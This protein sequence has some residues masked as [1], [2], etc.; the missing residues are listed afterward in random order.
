MSITT[1]MIRACAALLFVSALLSGC[2]A[3]R[4]QLAGS[5]PID[6][7]RRALPSD[8]PVYIRVAPVVDNRDP[9]EAYAL[10]RDYRMGAEVMR[11]VQSELSNHYSSPEPPAGFEDNLIILQAKI[12]RWDVSVHKGMWNSDVQAVAQIELEL[13]GA[14]YGPLYRARYQADTKSN[15]PFAVRARVQSVLNSAMDAAVEEIFT[16][17]KL[18]RKISSA[19]P[20]NVG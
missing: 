9:A 18:F 7:L 5:F 17:K 20:D 13:L 16:D 19:S 11:R 10:D 6:K 3:V 4:H 12:I 15:Q 14:D 8:R 2:G 1:K